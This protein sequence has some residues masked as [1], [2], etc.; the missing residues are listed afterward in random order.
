MLIIDK[1]KRTTNNNSK[2]I[3]EID[4]L[5]F[6]AIFTVILSHVHPALYKTL[7]S[8][9]N[10]TFHG[11]DITSFGYWIARAEVG[12]KVFFA[13]SGFILALPFIKQYLREDKKI[14]LK[15]YFYRRLTRLEPPFI[16]TTLFFFLIHI[17]VL[18]ESTRELLPNLVASLFY[19]H[20][21][22][23]ESAP[24]IN[25]VTWSLE[26][27]A[28]FY[29]TIPFIF[30]LFLRNMKNRKINFWF[31]TCLI[32]IVAILTRY[33][34]WYGGMPRLKFTVFTYI[35][36]FW[37]GVIIA[38][39]YIKKESFF[40]NK[41]FIW[42]IIGLCSML[43]M[44]YFY[45]P[46]FDTLNHLILNISIFLMFLS[47][48]KG[49]IFNWF[50]TRPLIYTIGGMCYTIYLL[51]YAFFFFLI[52][53][54]LKLNPFENYVAMYWLQAIIAIPIV[55]IV[56]IPFYLLVEKPCMDKHWPTK[57]A[58]WIKLKLN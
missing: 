37:T 17:L 3:P 32:V 36:N 20:G 45:K 1:L 30:I 43:L 27:E 26:L 33:Y 54:T 41:H 10:Y 56:S 53:Y 12:V 6:F 23:F 52:P 51:H 18:G 49:Y 2:Y 5:R 21:L 29:I 58:N 31:V 44:A 55:V 39:I 7:G 48:F 4:G 9:Y 13:I 14:N 8:S 28:Q 11:D 24:V 42:D 40:K 50:Y 16:V 25:P 47:A 57:L 19:L 34:G 22:I 46:Q 15:D 35:L 38:Y